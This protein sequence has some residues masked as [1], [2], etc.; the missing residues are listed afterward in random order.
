[1]TIVVGYLPTPE[2]SAAVDNAIARAGESGA[3]LV[4]VNTGRN[5]DYSHPNFATSQDLDALDAELTA[6]GIDHEIRQPTSGRPAAEEI[7][8]AA[9][10]L[11]ADLI[12]IGIR[13]RSP[14]GKAVTGSTA[15][16]VLLDATCPVLA[17]K[18]AR[19]SG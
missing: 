1:M 14:V 12:V 13:P 16:A 2:G 8:R 7:L 18:P 19:P 11:A 15:Q 3:R 9:A 6:A 5:G 10:E 17:V 4:V